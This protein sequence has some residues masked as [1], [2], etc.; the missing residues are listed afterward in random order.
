MKNCAQ[1]LHNRKVNLTREVKNALGANI[2]VHSCSLTSINLQCYHV[3]SMSY[4]D[5]KTVS[6]AVLTGALTPEQFKQAQRDDDYIAHLIRRKKKLNKFITIDN[7]LYFKNQFNLKLVL[8]ASLLDI[9]INAKHFTVFGLQISRSRI[10][11][12]IQQRYHVQ[13]SVLTKKTQK[14]GKKLSDLPVQCNQRKR[15]RT[16]QN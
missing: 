4:T 3:N 5:F 11:R 10:T 13:Q 7:L 14:T 6:I 8:P 16:L 2:P 1:T 12:D 15:S 9:V